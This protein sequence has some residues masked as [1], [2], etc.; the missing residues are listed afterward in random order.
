MVQFACHPE[1]AAFAMRRIWASRAMWRGFCG[2]I[3]ARLA[4]FLIK[5][6]RSGMLPP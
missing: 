2:T 1:Q 4:R 5:L 6:H 3:S